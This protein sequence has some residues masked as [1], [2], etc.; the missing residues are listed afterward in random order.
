VRGQF[1]GA[2]PHQFER[3]DGAVNFPLTAPPWQP[4]AVPEA[5]PPPAP[6]ESDLRDLL[7]DALHR[8]KL[9]ADIAE[10]AEAAYER[11]AQ[12]AQ[13]CRDRLT[14]FASL[15]QELSEATANA[16]RAGD[17]PAAARE[18]FASSLA[19][20]AQAEMDAGAAAN[21]VATLHT[22]QAAAV[23]N[24]ADATSTA[25]T[26]AARIVSFAAGK[27][28]DEVQA[29][30]E[31]INARRRTLLG[32][33]RFVTGHKAPLPPS[34]RS[35]LGT[36]TAREV[37]H[38]DP[39]PWRE[40]QRMLLADPLAAVEIPLPTPPV[41]ASVPVQPPVPVMMPSPEPP[42]MQ[43]DGDPFLPE[44]QAPLS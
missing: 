31:Q 32:F 15:E 7:A 28:V 6:S 27:L 19:A 30:Q 9:T 14:E 29:L 23:K 4:P 5:P 11:A 42:G 18:T 35:L 24:L 12:H 3:A 13:A 41:A 39:G 37:S 8:Q 44:V 1:A 10:R 22:E 2:L 16:L 40:A 34:V 20:R 26:L 17:D 33:D 21:A 38:A 43:D 36:P 25:N